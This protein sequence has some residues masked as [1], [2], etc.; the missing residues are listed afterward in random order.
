LRI[1]WIVLSLFVPAA[2]VVLYVVG[3]HRYDDSVH[4]LNA[5]QQQNYDRFLDESLIMS[6]PFPPLSDIP[7]V[8]SAEADELL[9]PDELIVGVELN[10]AARAYPVNMLNDPGRKVVNDVVGQT[11]IMVT[12]CDLCHTS[13]VFRREVRTSEEP[14]E[15]GC[16]GLLWNNSLVIYDI[17]TRSFWNQIAGKCVAGIRSG[18]QLHPLSSVLTSW[19]EWK[20]AYPQTDAVAVSRVSEYLYASFY[21]DSDRKNQFCYAHWEPYDGTAFSLAYLAKNPVLTLAS[22]GENLVI[23]TEP[24]TFGIR[25]FSSQLDGRLLTFQSIDDGIQDRETSSV[26]NMK[27]GTAISGTHSGRRLDQVPGYLAATASWRVLHPNGQVVSQS[28]P[29]K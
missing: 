17:D 3:S 22:N 14:E 12:W 19:G 11:A 26:W 7:T 23:V 2:V 27:T 8:T 9:R 15:F 28:S 25:T 21:Q 24:D 20:N 18:E 1:R 29:V 5:E 6:S 4:T 10:G 13:A 16:S